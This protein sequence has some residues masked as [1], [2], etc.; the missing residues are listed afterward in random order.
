MQAVF[1]ASYA[2]EAQVLEIDDFPPLKR[3]IES[4]LE[5]TNHFFGYFEEED[6]AGII[7]IQETTDHVDINSLVVKPTFFRRGIGR[8]L[9]AFAFKRFNNALF[10]VETGLEN[11]PA[12]RLYKSMGFKETRQW[13]TDFG[14]RKIQ[15]ERYSER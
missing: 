9:L 7:E 3:P 10:V 13:D 14:I 5:S 8:K 2:V 15:L 4:Y 6:L 1:Q 11:T 12:T